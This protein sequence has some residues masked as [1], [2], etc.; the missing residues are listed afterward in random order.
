M[1]IFV[2]RHEF[3][4]LTATDFA[5]RPDHRLAPPA[6]DRGGVG[7]SASVLEGT[8]PISKP[9]TTVGFEGFEGGERGAAELDPTSPNDRTV[10]HPVCR[11]CVPDSCT[12][13]T[14]GTRTTLATG[15]ISRRKS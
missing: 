6:R 4:C 9:V 13:T 10:V 1:S 12:T 5:G 8:L 15:A 2:S 11:L 3:V 7:H 14:L